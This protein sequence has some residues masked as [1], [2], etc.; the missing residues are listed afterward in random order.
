MRRTPPLKLRQSMRWRIN[1]WPY[2]AVLT[3]VT[4]NISYGKPLYYLIW[5]CKRGIPYRPLRSSP[6]IWWWILRNSST[7]AS[8]IYW[9]IKMISMKLM[10]RLYGLDFNYNQVLSHKAEERR[11]IN[12]TIRIWTYPRIFK[13]PSI[14]CKFL[15]DTSSPGS[16]FSSILLMSNTHVKP[17]VWSNYTWTINNKLRSSFAK[18]CQLQPTIH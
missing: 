17:L 7:I 3:E 4:W 2:Y 16:I 9:R 1:P 15:W 11:K 5:S 13:L 14:S 8:L 6:L 12:G 18:R 10:I